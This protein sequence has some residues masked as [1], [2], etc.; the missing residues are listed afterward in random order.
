MSTIIITKF[1]K[2]GTSS[3]TCLKRQDRVIK[4]IPHHLDAMRRRFWNSPFKNWNLRM[5]RLTVAFSKG[6]S[7]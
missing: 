6:G 3:V 4:I 7:R 5:E 2:D 1:H